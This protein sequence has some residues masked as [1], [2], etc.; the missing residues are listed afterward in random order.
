MVDWTVEQKAYLERSNVPALL[1]DMAL[2]VLREEPEDVLS[3]LV[4][5]LEEDAS[6]GKKRPPQTPAPKGGK[7]PPPPPPP[8]GADFFKKLGPKPGDDDAKARAALFADIAKGTDITKGLRKVSDTEK[9]HKNREEKEVGK[10]TDFTELERKKALRAEEAEKKR[11][12]T[13][14]KAKKAE[15]IALEGKQW[16]VE[17]VIGSRAQKKHVKLDEANMTQAVVVNDCEH[18]LLE[19]S[20]KVNSVFVNDCIGLSLLLA[21]GVVS[22][23]EV[24]KSRKTEVQASGPMPSFILDRDDELML[25]TTEH[26]RDVEITATAC[27]CVNVTFSNT[28]ASEDPLEKPI[29]EQFIT[30]IDM[31]NGKPKLVTRPMEHAA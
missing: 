29:P 6:L 19:I 21:R 14:A 1:D 10:V 23:V 8:P 13:T 17:S 18:I 27:T 31:A 22:S 9:R 25:Y 20:N 24:S 16:K 11:N 30:T 28:D 4:K 2:R 5:A 12:A 26:S 7:A 15:T 3:F